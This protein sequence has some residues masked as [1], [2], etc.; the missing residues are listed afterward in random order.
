MPRSTELDKPLVS[1]IWPGKKKTYLDDA[2]KEKAH[3]PPAKYDIINDIINVKRKSNLDKGP[4][5]TLADEIA[6]YNKKN[7]FPAPVAYS[8][9]HSLVIPNEYAC[10]KFKAERGSYLGDAMYKGSISPNYRIADHKLVE[11]R[12]SVHAYMKRNKPSTGPAFL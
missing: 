9:N 12:V 11:A 7:P 8:P 1:K 4:R 3:V 6:L 2:V 5:N 10:L